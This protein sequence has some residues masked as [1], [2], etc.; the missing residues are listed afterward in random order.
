MGSFQA[1]AALFNATLLSSVNSNTC[2]SPFVVIVSYSRAKTICFFIHI[3]RNYIKNN[4]I[5]TLRL[6]LTA[7][8][9]MVFFFIVST[10][11]SP[12]RNSIAG[13]ILR[14]YASSRAKLWSTMAHRTKP[15]AGIINVRSWDDNEDRRIFATLDF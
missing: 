7:A 14:G 1:G 9:C 11:P 5:C 12:P 10:R 3:Y 13:R 15:S 6:S 8:I 2:C 4:S